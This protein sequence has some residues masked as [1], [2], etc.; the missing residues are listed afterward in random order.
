MTTFVIEGIN[1][2]PWTA[3]ESSTGKKDGKFVTRFFK[4]EKLRSYQEAVK[5]SLRA[6]Y[7]GW[8]QFIEPVSLSFYFW[9]RLDGH[10]QVMDATN[11]Q[12]ALEDAIQGVL[13]GNDRQVKRITTIIFA[14]EATVMP[15]IVIGLRPYVE[16]HNL[17]KW[18]LM[19]AAVTGH[20]SKTPKVRQVEGVF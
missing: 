19:Q 10:A 4:D 6:D 15:K 9:R 12:K 2:E 11:A 7:P 1:P 13:I 17:E 3:S 14:Q 18:L 5:E 20:H 16:S 8:E